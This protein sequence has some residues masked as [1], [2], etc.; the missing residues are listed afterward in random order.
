G[1]APAQPAIPQ[2][3]VL[4]TQGV[5]LQLSDVPGGGGLTIEV[6]PPAVAI[7]LSMKFTTAGIEI[8]N[9]K[10]SI[11]LTTASVNVNDG[12]LEVI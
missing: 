1:Q 8:R 2:V 3:M 5:S 6:K 12:A 9:G 4:Q 10:N 11:K 7:P